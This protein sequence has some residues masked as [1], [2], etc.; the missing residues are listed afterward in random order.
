MKKSKSKKSKKTRKSIKKNKIYSMGGVEKELTLKLEENDVSLFITVPYPAN[1]P[2]TE[3]KAKNVNRLFG[4]LSCTFS[5]ENN[6]M[7][8]HAFYVYTHPSFDF[9]A[10]PAERSLTKDLGRRMLCRAVQ[11]AIEKEKITREGTI[12]LEAS[13][14]FGVCDVDMVAD[15]NRMSETDM[16]RFLANFPQSMKHTKKGIKKEDKVR[17][18]CEYRVN[19]NLVSYYKTYGLKEMEVDFEDRDIWVTPMIGR[20]QSVLDKC[21]HKNIIDILAFI[22]NLNV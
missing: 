15:I 14:S 18:I 17:M 5:K 9:G 7:F 8:L 16:D 2:L 11:H 22:R 3:F 10:S 1:Y 19:Q 4:E 20:I 21:I 12:R 13:A 6:E